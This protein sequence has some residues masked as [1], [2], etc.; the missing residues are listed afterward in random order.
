MAIML[1]EVVGAEEHSFTPDDSVSPTHEV[2]PGGL[3]V[4]IF[5][6]SNK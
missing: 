3:S 2:I 4:V 6:S 5:S 1:L